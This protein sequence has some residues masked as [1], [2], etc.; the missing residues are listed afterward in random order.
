MTLTYFIVT[1]RCRC[2]TSCPL[3]QILVHPVS[4]RRRSRGIASTLRLLLTRDERRT[5]VS[6]CLI[7]GHL[8][9]PRVSFGTPPSSPAGSRRTLSFRFL[10]SV[11]RSVLDSLARGGPS[12]FRQRVEGA[13]DGLPIKFFSSS[14]SC[15]SSLLSTISHD[16]LSANG[17]LNSYMLAKWHTL[18]PASLF[19]KMRTK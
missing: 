11:G 13:A 2:N 5:L 3:D 9:Q 16:I 7:R 18:E 4:L 8:S 15:C 6:S 19:R 17:R 1:I 14:S 12:N 10:P